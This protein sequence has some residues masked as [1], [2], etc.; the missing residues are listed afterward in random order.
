VKREIFRRGVRMTHR[1][2]ELEGQNDPLGSGTFDPK[3][4]ERMDTLSSKPLESCSLGE[5]QFREA[6][7]PVCK[8]NGGCASINGPAPD[9]AEMLARPFPVGSKRRLGPPKTDK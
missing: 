8:P 6:T 9:Y 5:H 1:F 4:P 2:G 3:F 7:S